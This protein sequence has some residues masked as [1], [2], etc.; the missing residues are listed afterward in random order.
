MTRIFR[1]AHI[2]TPI[3]KGRPLK[4]EEMGRVLVIEDGAIATKEGYIV[5]IG[6]ESDVMKRAPKKAEEIDMGGRCVIPGFVDPHT[7]ACF[8]GTREKEF[9]MRLQG[10]T[11]LEI[12]EKGG[13]ILST[14][15]NVRSASKEEL[16]NNTK[17]IVMRALKNGVTTMEIK[18]GYGLSL[19]H[20]VKMLEVI[21]Q[22]NGKPLDVVPTFMGAHAI[23]RE[24]KNDPQAYADLIIEKMI[25]HVAAK[26]LAKYCDVFCE[27]GVF[28]IEDT[29]RILSAAKD[30]GLGL[31]LHADEVCDLGGAKLAAEL[32]VDSAEHLLAAND[33]GL[34][35]MAESNVTAVLLPAT[36]LSLRKP[37]APAKKMIELGVP[38]ALA[39]DCN[40]GS[41]YCE[42]MEVVFRLA[43]LGMG[44]SVEE[45][46]VA[47]TINAAYAIGMA[48]LVGSL[49]KGKKADFVVLEGETPG[50]I[51]YHLGWFNVK[52]VYK[53]G[54]EVSL[55]VGTCL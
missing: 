34:K 22:L 41:C 9:V 32:K 7:H 15:D 40:P 16:Y 35:A 17:K 20:E 49:E 27:E 28:S 42:S 43:V 11:Y 46:L 26:K 19:E 37:Y 21:N 51:A 31:K 38:V 2:Y 25:P 5:D 18:S 29:R 1:N 3:D 36:A 33:E 6:R 50:V 12:L 30:H 55:G 47:S 54:Q 53:M 10:A 44:L 52:E 4:G 8:V 13:G 24:Y 45:A 48:S 39:T 14:V 23:P